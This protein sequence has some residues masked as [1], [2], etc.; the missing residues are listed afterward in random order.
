MTRS[1]LSD[2]HRGVLGRFLSGETGRIGR[3]LRVDPDPPVR[4]S[5]RA[6]S[7]HGGRDLGTRRPTARGSGEEE[8]L[9]RVVHHRPRRPGSGP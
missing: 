8:R 9:Q 4:P 3:V 7:A 6:C 2:A 1:A 5:P